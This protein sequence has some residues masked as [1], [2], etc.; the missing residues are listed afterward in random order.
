MKNKIQKMKYLFTYTFLFI[1][2]VTYSQIRMT[3]FFEINSTYAKT[4]VTTYN[5]E[6][7]KTSVEDFATNYANSVIKNPSSIIKPPIFNTDDIRQEKELGGYRFPIAAGYKIMWNDDNFELWQANAKAVTSRY[8]SVIPSMI[9]FEVQSTISGGLI[10]NILNLDN[11]LAN[12]I[13]YVHIGI[14]YGQDNGAGEPFKYF[15]KSKRYLH[16]TIYISV[17]F[18]NINFN[19]GGSGGDQLPYIFLNAKYYLK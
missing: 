3:P 12:L 8:N 19:L 9:G 14:T 11:N 16:G 7:I 2:F 5:L 17:P 4:K 13:R 18:D 6:N 10:N 15:D 1:T